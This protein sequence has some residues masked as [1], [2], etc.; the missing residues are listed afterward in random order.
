MR[1]LE[2]RVIERNAGAHDDAL[3]FSEKCRIERAAED[4]AS[5]GIC[6]PRFVETRRLL[7]GIDDRESIAAMQMAQ[8]R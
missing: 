7:T 5:V 1:K 6:A 3:R 8:A 2:Q 4:V